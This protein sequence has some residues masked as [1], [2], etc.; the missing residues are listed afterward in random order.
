MMAVDKNQAVVEFLL[1]CPQIQQSPLYF[2][3]INATNDA[4]QIMTVSNDTLLNRPYVDGSVLKRYSFTLLD[5]KSISDLALVNIIG[6]TNE[7][8]EEMSDVQT[9]I[10]WVKTQN[11][12]HNYPNFGQDCDIQEMKTTAENPT[13]EGVN[14]TEQLAMYS[15]TIQIDYIDN[16][17]KIWR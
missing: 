17:K 4:K 10:D 3:F 1:Q 5:F 15:F 2:N 16:S 9:L 14:E 7:N 6:Y 12:E 8:I 13:L 11:D